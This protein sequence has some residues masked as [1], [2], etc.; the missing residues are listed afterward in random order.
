[1]HNIDLDKKRF[2]DIVRGRVKNNFKKYIEHSEIIIPRGKDV[3]ALPVPRI[4]IPRFTYGDKLGGVGHGEGD[5]GDG[6]NSSPDGDSSREHALE[7]EV[8]LEEFAHMLCDALELPRLINKGKEQLP[9]MSTKYKNI[10]K[11]GPRSLVNTKRSFKETLKRVVQEGSYIPGHGFPLKREDLRYK[12]P[13]RVLLPD[14]RAV[15]IYMM[16]VSGSIDYLK[17]EII[18]T[19]EFWIDV[20]VRSQYKSIVSRYIAHDS[21]AW[22]VSQKEAFQLQTGGCTKMSSAL[23]LSDKIIE[24]EHNPLDWN[25][26]LFQFSDGDNLSDDDTKLCADIVR[27]RHHDINQYSYGEVKGDKKA[28]FKRVFEEYF[29]VDDKVVLTSIDEKSECLDALKLFLGKGN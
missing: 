26:Y 17:K 18:R 22:E 5:K 27:R 9:T 12:F 4:N 2:N 11:I 13:K 25:I 20:Y 6:L 10:A 7:L 23:E 1:M 3:F 24:H 15:V 21:R 8:S 28:S 16:D 29:G 19:I 14:P